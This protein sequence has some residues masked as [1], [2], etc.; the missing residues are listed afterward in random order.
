MQYNKN[1]QGEQIIMPSQI[2]C[3]HWNVIGIE[4]S[5]NTAGKFCMILLPAG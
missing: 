1:L 2:I 3:L 5:Q 4:L